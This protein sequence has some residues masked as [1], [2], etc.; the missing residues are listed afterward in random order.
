MAISQGTRAPL[1]CLRKPSRSLLLL[2]IVVIV[3][4]EEEGEEEE[5]EEEE[6]WWIG[7]LPGSI[8]PLSILSLSLTSLG[9]LPA[10]QEKSLNLTNTCVECKE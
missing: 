5:E 7:R 6:E 9:I 8:T 10:I 1:C 3:V 2:V 4:E